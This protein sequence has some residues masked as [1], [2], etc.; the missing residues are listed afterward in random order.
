MAFPYGRILNPIDLAENPAKVLQVA[1]DFARQ[2][3]GTIFLI[4]V[5]PAFVQPGDLPSYVPQYRAEKEVA[6]EKLEDIASRYLVGIKYE[7]VVEVG[8]PALAI[9]RA[10]TTLSADVIIMATHGRTGFN[11]AFFGSV[12]EEVLRET[13]CPVLTIR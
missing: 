8:S 1:T 11:R 5:I 10:A 7:I 9:L 13:P 3:D 2:N 12:A 6:H 4:Y